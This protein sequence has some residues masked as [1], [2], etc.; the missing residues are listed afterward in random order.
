[1]G[2]L[3]KLVNDFGLQAVITVA[4]LGGAWKF[5]WKMIEMM[6]LQNNRWQKVVEDLQKVS[7]QHRLDVREA[8]QYQRNEHEKL[9]EL[10][11]E[12]L[13]KSANQLET[14][15]EISLAVGRINGHTE[16]VHLHKREK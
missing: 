6:E 11:N 8:H 14:L 15:R 12:Q 4:V 7:E 5:L 10:Q 1:M 3:V 13:I 16:D 9:A 2:E